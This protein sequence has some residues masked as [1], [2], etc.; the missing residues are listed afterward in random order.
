MVAKEGVFIF[1][2][3]LILFMFCGLIILAIPTRVNANSHPEFQELILPYVSNAELIEDMSNAKIN[4]AYKK[5]KRKLFGWNINPITRDLTIDYVGDTVFAK[6]NN[7]S[8][9]LSFVHTFEVTDSLETSVSVSGDIQLELGI[10]GK[11]V[12]TAVDTKIRAEIGRKTKKT[13]TETLKTTIVIP[14]HTKVSV[15][16]KG[17]ARL[18]NGVAR[19]YFLGVST[20]KGTWEYIDVINEYYDYYEEN[21]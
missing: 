13:T 15:T 3:I 2:K 18:N 9:T 19:Y 10:K 12:T 5:V 16:I 14:A 11:K 17:K 1:K 4:N 8:N 7:T 21:I 6:A 20:K